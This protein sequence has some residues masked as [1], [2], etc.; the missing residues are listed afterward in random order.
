MQM[1]MS[2][3]RKRL[4]KWD[5]RP[6]SEEKVEPSHSYDLIPAKKEKRSSKWDKP[7]DD[8]KWDEGPS[9][10]KWD[11]RPENVAEQD[12]SSA[13]DS[14][15]STTVTAG[16]GIAA[17]AEAAARVNAMLMAKG[18]L[19]PAQP[20]LVNDSVLKSKPTVSCCIIVI[21]V[22]PNLFCLP[23]VFLSYGTMSFPFP[24]WHDLKALNL[25]D[26]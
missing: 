21:A 13:S 16:C 11:V 3:C 23:H 12:H 15:P 14:P 9:E 18:T 5:R 10:S 24:D 25:N 7:P 1:C 17:A 20:L 26:V 4:S 6:N 22:V 19:K 8:G 2:F